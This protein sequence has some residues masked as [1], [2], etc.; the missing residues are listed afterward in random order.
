MRQD[1][2]DFMDEKIIQIILFILFQLV[3]LASLICAPSP[4]ALPYPDSRRCERFELAV[5]SRA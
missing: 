5:L 4:N 3:V 1:E 2:Q